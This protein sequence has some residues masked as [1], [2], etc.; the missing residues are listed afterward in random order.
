M[1]WLIEWKHWKDVKGKIT[2]PEF[3]LDCTREKL[4]QSLEADGQEDELRQLTA[5]VWNQIEAD[6]EVKRKPRYS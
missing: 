3:D 1:D 5:K 2:A 4:I 6:C